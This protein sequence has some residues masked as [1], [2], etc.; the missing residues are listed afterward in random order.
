MDKKLRQA[1]G[2]HLIDRTEDHPVAV[3]EGEVFVN[4]IAALEML[5]RELPRRQHSLAVSSVDDIAIIIDIDKFVVRP[6]LLQLGVGREQRPVVPQTDIIN[7]RFMALEIL[8]G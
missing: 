8:R 6:D 2:G 3:R 4:P 1:D 7:R 5:V